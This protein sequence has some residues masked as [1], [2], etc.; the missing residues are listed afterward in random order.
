MRRVVAG[1]AGILTAILVAGCGP[2]ESEA[3]AGTP[4]RTVA[5]APA[6]PTPQYVGSDTC[7]GCHAAAAEAWEGSHHELAMALPE[8]DAVRAPFAGE[9]FEFDGVDSVFEA[10]AA[11]LYVTTEGPGGVRDRFRVRYTFGIEPL[12]QYLL[13]LPE[14]RLQASSVAW[15]TRPG[16]EGWFRLYSDLHVAADDVLHW[17]A[18]SQNWNAVCAD[19]HS[20][21]LRK[22]YSAETD[23]YETTF[24]EVSVGCEACHGPGSVHVA[25]ARAGA[26]ATPLAPL[27]DQRSQVE[28]C[29]PCHSR[30]EQL[31][32]GHAPP[33]AWLDHYLPAL[34]DTDLYHRD[35]QILDEVYV[36]G[37]FLQSR[38]H[39]AGVR[40]TDCHDPHRADLLLS[41]NAVCTQCHAEGGRPDFPT[42]RPGAYDAPEHHFHE[43]GT[44]GARCVSC[45][46]TDRT[47]MEVD[48]R[49]D[50]SFRVPRPDL[51]M[52]TGAPDACTGCHADASA[53]WAAAEIEA[54]FGPDRRAHFG[55][56]L[57]RARDRDP[58]AEQG[59]AAL[60]ADPE[61]PDLVRASVLALMGD[62]ERGYSRNAI[63]AALESPE[64]ILRLGAARGAA[65]FAPA[66]RWRLL[67]P[68][69]DDAVLAVRVEAVRTLLPVARELPPAAR[70]RWTEALHAYRLQLDAAADGADGQTA[71]A[72]V[73]LALG[74]PDA[75]AAA[76]ERALRVN[77]S[78]VPALVNL[79][80]LHRARGRDVLAGP[81]LERA[82]TLAP[83][84]VDVLL[85]RALWLVR[86]RR[87][88]E[89]LDLLGRARGLD[90]GH[91][92]ATYL[93]A[94]ALNSTGEPARALDALDDYLAL[95]PGDVELR[96]LAFG[97]ARDAGL[98]IRAR[99]YERDGSG[100]G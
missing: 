23:R 25:E 62:Y 74:R 36:W 53:R 32:E 64:P 39:E 79:A 95:R 88:P 99:R 40:C 65:R 43:P 6:A 96:R 22:G 63:V 37:S 94:V 5:E 48:A 98:L 59:L 11:G 58:E 77:P 15:D 83:E 52:A 70:P 100:D 19:C 50:H 73:E 35:G 49:R 16:Q 54:R 56:M 3:D 81:L 85:A 17:S 47:Y 91:G 82:E 38:M 68:L 46:M 67:A 29:A 42:L 97:I 2:P 33:G 76:L 34:L 26:L 4:A 44:E 10:D 69:L 28:S 75:A 60:A 90:P 24:S 18:P 41:G 57:A 27:T 87:T 30:R 13:E 72:S 9:H 89:A 20:T 8:A 21:N 92:R 93:L 84:S 71:I 80:D 31:A 61:A 14:G 12:Q 7:A 45:H 1:A 55:E 66:D 78:W 86:A 51:A